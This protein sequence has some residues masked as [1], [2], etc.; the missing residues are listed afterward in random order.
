MYCLNLGFFF[1]GV[2][3]WSNVASKEFASGQLFGTYFLFHL[4]FIQV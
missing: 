1:Q 3:V 2:A 4:F